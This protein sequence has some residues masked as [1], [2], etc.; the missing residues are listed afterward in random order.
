M[1][2][3]DLVPW[4]FDSVDADFD[5]ARCDWRYHDSEY[6]TDTLVPLLRAG[7]HAYK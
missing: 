2:Y 1:A 5:D 3:T 4:D 7:L 6:Y